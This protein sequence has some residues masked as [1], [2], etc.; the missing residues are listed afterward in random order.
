MA[1]KWTPPSDAVETKSTTWTPP[2]DAVEVKKKVDTS[3]PTSRITELPQ[4]TSLD[5]LSSGLQSSQ[6]GSGTNLGID[7]I[8]P[9]TEE[10]SPI[11]APLKPTKDQLLPLEDKTKGLKKITEG[12][13]ETTSQQGLPSAEILQ[14][15][16][17]PIIDKASTITPLKLTPEQEASQK[18]A[19]RESYSERIFNNNLKYITPDK[20]DF[21]EEKLVPYLKDKFGKEGF[22]FDEAGAGDEMIVSYTGV[23]SYLPQRT[24]SINLQP[25]SDEEK[26]IEHQKLINF[27]KNTRMSES[28]KNI[29]ND[30]GYE[31]GQ[32]IEVSRE[33]IE[34]HKEKLIELMAKDP[35]KYGDNLVDKDQYY[36]LVKQKGLDLSILS[37][38]LESK[39]KD[40]ADKME[41]YKQNPTEEE[42]LKLIKESNGLD[43]L[44]ADLKDKYGRYESVQKNYQKAIGMSVAKKEKEGNFLGMIE[45]GLAQG[46]TGL[47]KQLFNTAMD[48]IPSSLGSES[49]LD[50]VTNNKLNE[51]GYT[52]A[53]KIDYASKELKKTFM[54]KLED[55]ITSFFSGGT[56]TEEYRASKDRGEFE[57]V[58]NMLSESLG[59]AAGGGGNPLLTQV[60]FTMMSKNGIE[61]EMRGTDFDGLTEGEKQ[62]VAV[63]YS[64]TIGALEH[65][66]FKF[67]TLSAK[68][69]VFN[70]FI[71]SV[72][73]K[74]LASLPKNASIDLIEKVIS[75]ETASLLLDSGLK[76]VG[77]ALV[78]GATEGIQKID[79]IAIKNISNAI[80]EKDY[81]KN[82]PDL[83]TTEGVMET[84]SA[85]WE[86]AKYGFYGGLIMAGGSTALSSINKKFNENKSNEEFS[87]FMENMMDEKLLS[88]SIEEINRKAELGEISNEEATE[89]LKAIEVAK[90]TI[91]SIPENLSVTEK[92][93]SYDLINER[94][95]LEKEIEG[96]DKNLVSAK[97]EKINDI[98]ERLKIIG[99][100]EVKVDEK[101]K[102]TETS[103]VSAEKTTE[104][105]TDVT[106][107][108]VGEIT[109]PEIQTV[110]GK[111][112]AYVDKEGKFFSEKEVLNMDSKELSE[113]NLQN[114]SE[115]VSTHLET[116][117]PAK[118]EESATSKDSLQVEQFGKTEQ[119]PTEMKQ[120]IETNVQQDK[121]IQD[122]TKTESSTEGVNQGGRKESN[123]KDGKT[124]KGTPRKGNVAKDTDT[125][126]ALEVDVTTPYQ[127][128]LKYFIG[129]GK[130]NS[131]SFNEVIASKLGNGKDRQ[132][133]IALLNNKTGKSVNELAHELWQETVGE[134]EIDTQEFRNA[135]IEVLSNHTNT[136][137]MSK[138]I[139]GADYDD[140]IK[141]TY[142]EEGSLNPDY[143]IDSESYFYSLPIEE[144]LQWLEDEATS[145]KE[146]I[147]KF[148]K[149]EKKS[150]TEKLIETKFK[151]VADNIRKLK[152]TPP[153]FTN[154]ETGEEFDFTKQGF[155]W[156][157]LV[158]NIAVAVEKTGDVVGSVKEYLGKQDWYN[159][160]TDAQKESF[161]S[162]VVENLPKEE[163]EATPSAEKKKEVPPSKP[164]TPSS[165]EAQS[166]NEKERAFGKQVLESEVSNEIKKGISED[167]KKYIPT[168]N[169]VSVAEANYIIQEKGI[170][171]SVNMVLDLKNELSPR[172]RITL[173]IQL[174][175][176]LNKQATPDSYYQAAQ[177]ADKLSQYAT[178]LG[179]GI[180]VFSL[181]NKLDAD[182]V[183]QSYERSQ[184]ESKDKVK[185][186]HSTTFEGAVEGYDSG[187]REAGKKATQT[188]FGK[189]KSKASKIKA[190]GLD[191]SEIEKRKKAAL[192]K[193]KK[194]TTK[195]GGTLTSGGL[196]KEAIEA[197]VEYGAMVFADGVRNFKEW[198]A[199]IKEVAPDLDED[200]LKSIWMN[201]ESF[202]GKTFDELSKL[203]EIEEVVSNHFSESSDVNSLSKKLQ[204]TFGL[205][206]SLAD[207]L[208][209]EITEEF[210]RIVEKERKTEID[211][212]TPKLTKKI[213]QAIDEIAQGENLSKKEIEDII[214]KAFGIEKLTEEQA[215]K[216]RDLT[217]ERDSRPE[218]FLKDEITRET[219]SY[220]ASLNGIPK[221]DIFW[222]IYYASIL[223]GYETQI[224]NIAS[225]SLN[226]ALESFVTTIQ[227]A[228]KKEGTL[229]D[230]AGAIGDI[231]T[232]LLKGMKDG[233]RELS[234]ILSTGHSARKIAQKL[235]AKDT[236]ENVNFKG[237]KLNPFNYYKYVGRFMFAV[238][239]AAFLAANGSKKQELA[240]EVAQK[241]GLHGKA[242]RNRISEI[243]NESE[244]SYSQ[245]NEQATKEIEKIDNSAP[246]KMSERQKARLIK[247]RTSE[248]LSEMIPDEIQEKANDYSSFV[249]FNYTPKGV[250][251]TVASTLSGLG[252]KVPAFKFVVPFTRV[253]ANVLNQQLD[254]TPYGYLRASG[255]NFGAG[256]KNRTTAE[257][258]ND[259]NRLLIKATLGTAAMVSLYALAKSYE[260]DDDPYF[261]ISGK[262]PSDM[263]KKNQLFSQGWR[264]YSIKIGDK[265]ISYQYTPLGVALSFI[266]NW[267][268]NEKYKE[269]DEKDFLTKSTFA[270]KSS[271]S[272]ILDMSFLTGLSGFF[273]S[274]SKDSDAETTSRN[275]QKTAGKIGTTFIPNLFKQL[276]KLYDPTIYDSKSIQASILKEI[277][278]VKRYSDLKP[279]LNAFGQPV[280]KQG[281]R[282]FQDITKD[283]VW[284]FMAKNRIFAP[285]ASPNTHTIYGKEMSDAEFYEYMEK[286]GKLSYDYFKDNLSEIQSTLDGL[287][288][289]EKQEYINE[290]FQDFRKEVKYELGSE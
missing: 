136:G 48:V 67:S 190:F 87:V 18:L 233:S 20:I 175:E 81:F 82:I 191:K 217:Q 8:K 150:S 105:K 63:P 83:T 110:E 254:Y 42:R 22:V 207:G 174:I 56:T 100:A 247:I 274:L 44:R 54:P 73:S 68:N 238:D 101:T 36:E 281:N 201:N 138:E 263:N 163:T 109:K 216:I 145:E 78:E 129:G 49:S 50:A 58:V 218:G 250:L 146:F 5:A 214:F 255:F 232:G 185:K 4:K 102:P 30:L 92:R 79:E 177:V 119:L 289:A 286:S 151:K 204:D 282:F 283:K 194:A 234:Q 287:E 141:N 114:P 127:K 118:K 23:D 140:Y 148:D 115:S 178:D 134:K 183:I 112:S 64:L 93:K 155:D 27:M 197:V 284:L 248:I 14:K 165:E 268:D 196:N 277:P 195:G 41:I 28:E 242:M 71:K 227:K 160:M 33:Q 203:A 135:I 211:K 131:D 98:N 94:A 176:V 168:S 139:L 262:G 258:I 111:E 243:L 182:G 280:E 89:Q 130:I 222:S 144:K 46:I 249:T 133:A 123:P 272:G 60:S 228:V 26:A 164:T 2:T 172:V 12:L 173:G 219:L 266:G 159:K 77:G 169:K 198:S 192:E 9:S 285:A 124:I 104:T 74:S 235:E 85:A 15:T 161:E 290:I 31:E 88:T 271:A 13:L 66:G 208:A 188:I 261:D 7:L 96:K 128:V 212:K 52:E 270:M 38:N 154:P 276:D 224:L 170:Q 162:Q 76:I 288:G 19:V 10:I 29:A 278:I 62:L 153:K 202:G 236:L 106:D 252:E 142:G 90:A 51:L 171:E 186:K 103:K 220:M 126:R 187:T 210:N 166:P 143:I 157:D 193:L 95:K 37:K 107:T 43:K 256:M 35:Y 275:F 147:E 156:N 59:A 40:F 158:E 16:G 225:N 39:T 231:F 6:A 75:K 125:K 241:E 113:M 65:L 80:T 200:D 237:G 137:T 259:R 229:Q 86:D 108:N 245:A 199:K 117:F 239:S 21:N 267:L 226:I 3:K 244:Q 265:R 205:D 206:E 189:S 34:K 215:Q 246:N 251:G 253:V 1:K 257:N 99:G 223:S 181:W 24:I 69:P 45:G 47:Q 152:T 167:A 213:Q 72:V 149:N 57:K 116:I 221:K 264:P 180:Q 184:K 70:N 240:R 120:N 91:Q 97:T 32:S 61:K 11:T 279:K 84:L 230:R 122:G 25:F 269:L 209:S 273:E 132:K 55:G 179:Q 260:D 17:I 121:K 53:E